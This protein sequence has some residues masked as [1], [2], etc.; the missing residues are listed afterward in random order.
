[1][2]LFFPEFELRIRWVLRISLRVPPKRS[3]SFAQHS[4]ELTSLDLNFEIHNIGLFFFQNRNCSSSTLGFLLTLTREDA[5]NHTTIFYI[6]PPRDKEFLALV[7][8]LASRLF[9]RLSS[10]CPVPVGTEEDACSLPF[11][12]RSL[13]TAGLRLDTPVF[14]APSADVSRFPEACECR[15]IQESHFEQDPKRPEER[16]FVVDPGA[17][18]HMMSK[19]ELSS[20]ELDTLRRSRLPMEKCTPT[21]KHKFS[22]TISTCS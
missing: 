19:K 17:S 7:A 14:F 2:A 11:R 1:M 15:K 4:A 16:E 21:R 22:F 3:I 20:E 10:V 5:D 18:L 6:L 9:E 13:S 12:L 8:G